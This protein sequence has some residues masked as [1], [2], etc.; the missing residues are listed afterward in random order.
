MSGDGGC[1]KLKGVEQRYHSLRAQL[2]ELG[3]R[4]PLAI[5]CLPLV[6]ALFGDLLQTTSS[7]DHY[8]KKAHELDEQVRVLNRGVQPFR[9]DNER[10]VRQITELNQ[11]VTHIREEANN[12]V[13]DAKA[14]CRKL[15]Q[16][17]GDLQFLVSQH[18]ARIR[19]L[20]VESAEKTKKLLQLQSAP[21]V[22]L[23][24]KKIAQTKVEILSSVG[25][26]KKQPPGRPW[27]DVFS[28]A[29]T[30]TEDPFVVNMVDR[31]QA[32]LRACRYEMK[33]LREESEKLNET[34]SSLKQQVRDRDLDIAKL[35][36]QLDSCKSHAS[37]RDPEVMRDDYTIANLRAAIGSLEDSNQSLR[38]Q[39]QDA[40]RKQHEAMMRAVRLA[41][42]NQVL[43][44][45]IRNVDNVAMRVEDSCNYTVKETAQRIIDLQEQLTQS[46]KMVAELERS[47][48]EARCNVQNLLMDLEK[49]RLE[50]KQ[51]LETQRLSNAQSHLQADRV[52]L[53]RYQHVEAEL[54]KEI[55]NLVAA[56]TYQKQKIADLE[57]KVA[58]SM[59]GPSH[60][61]PN[62][63]IRSDKGTGS[64]TSKGSTSSGSGRSNQTTG[65]LKNQT[66]LNTPKS[67]SFASSR[68]SSTKR[69]SCTSPTLVVSSSVLNS[70]E[71]GH[72]LPKEKGVMFSYS[73][74]SS[75]RSGTDVTRDSECASKRPIFIDVEKKGLVSKKPGATSGPS[76]NSTGDNAKVRPT[77]RSAAIQ[78]DVKRIDS[79]ETQV[80]LPRETYH[81]P[82]ERENANKPE[83]RG[84]RQSDY[85]Y[86]E[87]S[88]GPGKHR[89][90]QD[91]A[92]VEGRR[93][94]YASEKGDKYRETEYRKERRREHHKTRRDEEVDEYISERY[95][96]EDSERWNQDQRK[97]QDRR[98]KDNARS[99]KHDDPVS[100]R[101]QPNQKVD[102]G[103]QSEVGLSYPHSHPCMDGAGDG[104]WNVKT[105]PDLCPIIKTLEAERNFFEKEY[106]RIREYLDN[107]PEKPGSTDLLWK[108]REAHADLDAIRAENH[109]LNQELKDLSAVY[110]CEAADSRSHSD[111]NRALAEKYTEV[112]QRLIAKEREL[113][114]VCE[115]NH[116]L[117]SERDALRLLAQRET[118]ERERLSSELH[119]LEVELDLLRVKKSADV[120]KDRLLE[121]NRSLRVE[122]DILRG[123]KGSDSTLEREREREKERLQE[124]NKRLRETID[125]LKTSTMFSS[126]EK[127]CYDKPP[128]SV[129]SV[130]DALHDA[131][132]RVW[133]LEADGRDASRTF[134][135]EILDLRSQL[136]NR[137]KQ[138][139]AATLQSE[140]ARTR[141]AELQNSL[142]QANANHMKMKVLLEETQRNLEQ[143]QN[144]LGRLQMDAVN[145]Q[146]H[147]Q[148][149][150]FDRVALEKEANALRSEVQRLHSSINELENEKDELIRTADERAEQVQMLSDD[151]RERD[152]RIKQLEKAI[153]DLHFAAERDQKVR[154]E[155]E[156]S[157][158]AMTRDYD[159]AEN[160]RRNLAAASE[161]AAR[162]NK[163]LQ[164]ELAAMTASL[165][166]TTDSYEESC[167]EV[168]N[169]KRQLQIYV[170]EVERFEQLLGEKEA[171]RSDMLETFRNLSD[172]ASK[173]DTHNMTLETEYN[174]MR[175]SLDQ[176]RE[177][178]HSLNHQLAEKDE[179][180]GSYE[181]QIEQLSGSI[182]HLERQVEES[183]LAR[184]STERDLQSAHGLARQLESQKEALQDMLDNVQQQKEYAERQ[185]QDLTEQHALLERQQQELRATI[186]S[187][188]NLLAE[189][190]SQASAQAARAAELEQDNRTM[191][192]QL[193]ALQHTVD[194]LTSRANKAEELLER[195]RENVVE[196]ERRLQQSMSQMEK[197][198]QQQSSLTA[199][200]SERE[201]EVRQ[202]RADNER[203][204]QTLDDARTEVERC[205]DTIE[206]LKE[207]IAGLEESERSSRRHVADARR[208]AAENIRYSEENRSSC[209]C[210][211]PDMRRNGVSTCCCGP[212]TVEQSKKVTS[213]VAC[214]CEP[215][216]SEPRNRNV[217]TEHCPCGP[218]PAEHNKKIQVSPHSNRPHA[219]RRTSSQREA[220]SSARG[221]QWYGGDVPEQA[222][223]ITAHIRNTRFDA[224]DPSVRSADLGWV[225]PMT[226]NQANCGLELK[227]E[228][229]RPACQ[230]TESEM[231]ERTQIFG[232]LEIDMA[233][234][235]AKGG[236]LMH[237]Q[238]GMRNGHSPKVPS[239]ESEFEGKNK[240][241]CL[242]ISSIAIPRL[243]ASPE[244][245]PKS[246]SLSTSVSSNVSRSTTPGP[247]PLIQFP[248]S[249]PTSLLSGSAIHLETPSTVSPS[250]LSSIS[251][252][253]DDM[254]ESSFSS[255]LWK[256]SLHSD[257]HPTLKR[258]FP[259]DQLKENMSNY[260]TAH[261]SIV[262]S[263]ED[264]STYSRHQTSFGSNAR[265][266]EPASS[267]T[268]HSFL[269]SSQDHDN[270]L[271]TDKEE[272]LM[273]AGYEQNSHVESQNEKPHLVQPADRMCQNSQGQRSP[274]DTVHMNNMRGLPVGDSEKTRQF[275]FQVGVTNSHVQATLQTMYSSERADISDRLNVQTHN[276]LG[277]GPLLPLFQLQQQRQQIQLAQQQQQLMQQQRLMQQ[278]Q[279]LQ[280]QQVLEQ[281]C[282]L[283]QQLAQQQ[284][285]LQK[286]Q[287]EQH[288]LLQKELQHLQSCIEQSL[289]I[290]EPNMPCLGTNSGLDHNQVSNLP[291][292]AL[293]GGD[294]SVSVA[295]MEIALNNGHGRPEISP[296]ESS[297]TS[298]IK[299]EVGDRPTSCKKSC[300]TGNKNTSS[301]AC[302]NQSKTPGPNPRPEGKENIKTDSAV[303]QNETGQ[304]TK[305]CGVRQKNSHLNS[306]SMCLSATSTTMSTKSSV[307]H[308]DS[309]KSHDL[310][311]CCFVTIP[312][313]LHVCFQPGKKS[314]NVLPAIPKFQKPKCC[315][316]K[317]ARSASK[318]TSLDSGNFSGSDE[319][320]YDCN[321][322]GKVPLKHQRHTS[323][324]ENLAARK[325][326][327]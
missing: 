198:T 174:S 42:R 65:Y 60:S 154:A 103:I 323:F 45:E 251:T 127:M 240:N 242:R 16:E 50:N 309:H 206:N 146:E 293:G 108:L 264:R 136:A 167:R 312:T 55:E 178:V 120:E 48:V 327:P 117:L 230:A 71:T 225:R 118:H 184:E 68:F 303:I 1:C 100:D 278:Q 277:S 261:S 205:R 99:K 126:S 125:T 246:A 96:E 12:S 143:T 115:E 253:E 158:R 212:P 13:L 183:R 214:S 211:P 20:E 217:G 165:R 15:E 188:E 61:R 298:H 80:N 199:N 162:E 121:E 119:T 129:M 95:A 288:K 156:E 6:E 191:T 56:V 197:Q 266:S 243:H 10:L 193:E 272:S 201:H 280:E 75:T 134:D 318:G 306:K 37:A 163:R 239:T 324:F 81:E 248:S 196:Y 254:T 49:L 31:S 209:S 161:G 73:S 11:Q 300:N 218:P 28:G 101:S 195:N 58:T 40:L 76:K 307:S 282:L 281:E 59:S 33:L 291:L 304:D 30:Q 54:T 319:I 181:K 72:I 128:Q 271:P 3:F 43:Q 287:Q 123:Q 311:E 245:A 226:P 308:R 223:D 148:K 257:A 19:S 164:E 63:D 169:M 22:S 224:H 238:A 105:P 147:I 150:E 292:S 221:A 200:A 326:D 87:C 231:R 295:Q 34:I 204:A 265:S 25:P 9:N 151:I 135:K 102:R 256:T 297:F 259:E 179:I 66:F 84:S 286:Q 302:S 139:D 276:L 38:S 155:L 314:S 107:M 110:R 203:L 89:N 98:S 172:E 227:M 234:K 91:D 325:L 322:N 268:R 283:Q 106:H 53:S 176:Y 142:G 310:K 47:G 52:E 220:H 320:S 270:S 279:E 92:N 233:S 8:K 229:P 171:E 241:P 104:P 285:L 289:I 262:D 236:I 114:S 152:S 208:E 189:S 14:R 207:R 237:N 192:S 273:S 290:G 194:Q 132:K 69:N 111:V 21:S 18:L 138:L 62:G 228:V 86:S 141:L 2:D 64:G 284:K 29:L 321:V 232:L 39:L 113:L 166:A 27:L 250:M 93:Q 317:S 124:E 235:M 299:N 275:R 23:G 160:A 44:A 157:L 85:P 78:T 149:L 17:N 5:E 57:E 274:T 215:P 90:N 216:P 263:K 24:K 70:D 83:R 296:E 140:A 133:T 315:K 131:Q 219:S 260:S 36:T 116:S 145:Q 159:E 249:C 51:L 35:H 316:I 294:K 79:K 153:N 32:E 88:E 97:D 252:K 26:T 7:L 130:V 144:D 41:E 94:A 122:I 255:K 190:R 185:T 182:A 258:K 269:N 244:D 247:N 202:M 180:V 173:L 213:S 137:T 168:E 267:F 67:S 222:G 77:N 313:S 82:P 177:Q 305:F 4:Q 74:A 112:Q 175:G 301:D 186:Q 109:R 210:G 187:M 170:L 46:Q